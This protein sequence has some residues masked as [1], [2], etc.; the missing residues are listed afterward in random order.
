MNKKEYIQIKGARQH[1]APNS[2]SFALFSQPQ[3]RKRLHPVAREQQDFDLS[4]ASFVF[5]E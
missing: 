3:A 1:P 5:S 2:N 4:D